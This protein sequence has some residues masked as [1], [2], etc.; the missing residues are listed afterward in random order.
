MSQT[1]AT[2]PQGCVL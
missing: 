1:A 2:P